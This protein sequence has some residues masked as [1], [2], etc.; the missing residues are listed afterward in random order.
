MKFSSL[1]GEV[2]PTYAKSLLSAQQCGINLLAIKI[3]WTLKGCYFDKELKIDL[4]EW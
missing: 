4:E 1:A 2:D 3:N